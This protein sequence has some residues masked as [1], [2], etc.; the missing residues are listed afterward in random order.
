MLRHP[1]RMLDPALSPT[2][3]VHP[4]DRPPVVIAAPER[5]SR[6]RNARAV[7]KLA[8][9][10]AKLLLR[11]WFGRGSPRAAGVLLRSTFEDLGGL[12]IKA[13]QLLSLR[14]DLLPHRFSLFI[15][16]VALSA[17]AHA[18]A[19]D[20]IRALVESGS[21]RAAGSLV[22]THRATAWPPTKA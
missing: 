11:K 17:A 21:A 16:G 15:A 5:P 4:S 19:V 10:A 12:W 20:D 18:A 9:L 1:P 2:R 7:A 22:A 8:A 6:L 13:G 3:L 14:I